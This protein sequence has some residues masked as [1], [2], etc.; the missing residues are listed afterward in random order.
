MSW[1]K[2][3]KNCND[4]KDKQQVHTPSFWPPYLVDAWMK[5]NKDCL[6]TLP[7]PADLS[8][9]FSS[10]PSSKSSENSN[11]NFQIF[12][13]SKSSESPSVAEDTVIVIHMTVCP[14]TPS[15]WL[16]LYPVSP[17]CKWEVFGKNKSNMSDSQSSSSNKSHCSSDSG[18]NQPFPMEKIA[19]AKVIVNSQTLSGRS[20]CA[21][22]SIHA[23]FVMST[24][25]VMPQSKF[26]STIPGLNVSSPAVHVKRM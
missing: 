4:N 25:M 7:V 15:H 1:H 19:D 6:K 21:S 16:A 10:F 11:Q 2:H 13:T 23:P 9:S 17:S 3:C 12:K 18:F 24:P 22:N 20:A 8:S 14:D 5:L 26:S